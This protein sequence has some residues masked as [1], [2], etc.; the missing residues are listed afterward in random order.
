MRRWG[1]QKVCTTWATAGD[2]VSLCSQNEPTVRLSLSRWLL[3]WLPLACKL[4]SFSYLFWAHSLCEKVS[5]VCIFGFLHGRQVEP[6][7]RTDIVTGEAFAVGI[8]QPESVLGG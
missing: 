3:R 1:F 4:F 2:S 8:H 6:H 5:K 7:V